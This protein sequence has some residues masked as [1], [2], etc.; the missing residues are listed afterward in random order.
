MHRPWKQKMGL[1]RCASFHRGVRGWSHRRW[2]AKSGTIKTEANRDNPMIIPAMK[3]FPSLVA[4]LACMGC[5]PAPMANPAV[6]ISSSDDSDH[7]LSCE[8]IGLQPTATHRHGAAFTI[9]IR[10]EGRKTVILPVLEEVRFTSSIRFIKDAPPGKRLSELLA[11]GGWISG[12]FAITRNSMDISPPQFDRLRAGECREYDFRW[13]PSRGDQG[14]GALSI[15][16]PHAFP[17]IPLQPMTIPK[18]NHPLYKNP[19]F[20]LTPVE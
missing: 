11:S 5:A 2:V 16:L 6:R 9:R 12:D 1:P 17:E 20:P 3:I 8:L 10:N 7:P 18:S 14:S 4:I 19:P 15:V 13:K